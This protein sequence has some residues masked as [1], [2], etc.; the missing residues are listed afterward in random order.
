[1]LFELIVSP[2]TM[3]L[4]RTPLI[5]VGYIF[6][7]IISLAMVLG[8][9]FH[10]DASRLA[11]GFPQAPIADLGVAANHHRPAFVLE[12]HHHFAIFAVRAAFLQGH[13]FGLSP[14]SPAMGTAIR[15]VGAAIGD[16]AK[17]G[18]G[19]GSLVST[20][21]RVLD[22]STL[23]S[24]A[25]AGRAILPAPCRRAPGECGG[26]ADEEESPGSHFAPRIGWQRRRIS[27]RMD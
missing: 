10:G 1:M 13:T 20:S 17:V 26:Q 16:G 12:P 5:T 14:T 4:N 21:L 25:A 23:Y 6:Q 2:E 24:S 9:L 18:G 11:F 19:V 27:R 22:A 3:A 8:A 15:L 7:L